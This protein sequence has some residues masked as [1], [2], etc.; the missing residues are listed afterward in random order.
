MNPFYL[1]SFIEDYNVTTYKVNTEQ[2]KLIRETFADEAYRGAFYMSIDLCARY[3]R[4]AFER[5]FKK[6]T[7]RTFHMQ[8]APA[9]V[10]YGPG[11]LK[12]GFR[13]VDDIMDD[14][15][16]QIGD[17]VIYS[18]TKTSPWGHIQVWNGKQWVSDYRQ[19]SK[20][21]DKTYFNLVPTYYRYFG[22]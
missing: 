14:S 11:L 17:V 20:Y 16:I 15:Q 5:A 2:V 7:N 21:P 3:V 22:Y 9:A 13:V 10:N 1:Y 4:L 6:V 19:S 12:A 8:Q 18:I